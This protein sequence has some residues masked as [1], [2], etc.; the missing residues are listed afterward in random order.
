MSPHTA[1]ENISDLFGCGSVAAMT[2]ILG[3]KYNS[4]WCHGRR[5]FCHRICC[6]RRFNAL[7]LPGRQRGW[8]PIN[9]SMPSAVMQRL[10][11][12]YDD[13]PFG[14]RASSSGA[15]RTCQVL[16]NH[17][18]GLDGTDAARQP[19]R[20]HRQWC[21]VDDDRRRRGIRELSDGTRR[22]GVRPV[23]VQTWTGRH[24]PRDIPPESQHS[25]SSTI[26]QVRADV[27]FSCQEVVGSGIGHVPR[28]GCSRAFS[29][30]VSCRSIFYATNVHW[31]ALHLKLC[32]DMV[33]WNSVFT[34]TYILFFGGIYPIQLFV[35]LFL[36]PFISASSCSWPF[37]KINV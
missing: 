4:Y 16:T 34:L 9:Q 30:C 36:F 15:S 1:E 35:A 21:A 33:V 20:C 10:T 17:I 5:R 24:L 2:F 14:R 7:S 12:S 29:A 31:L 6:C 19:Q 3:L 26:V 28:A 27:E 37:L 13:V 32:V 8:H 22:D 18:S 25:S 11:I 23:D